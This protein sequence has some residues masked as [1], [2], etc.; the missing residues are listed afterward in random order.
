MMMKSKILT[1]TVL[2][3]FVGCTNIKLAQDRVVDE[4]GHICEIIHKQ[5]PPPEFVDIWRCEANGMV[6][7]KWTDSLSVPFHG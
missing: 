6:W 5:G 4:H 3:S 2:L 1:C 7:L